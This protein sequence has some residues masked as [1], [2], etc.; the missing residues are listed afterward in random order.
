MSEYLA[1]YGRPNHLSCQSAHFKYEASRND[2]K[3]SVVS[4]YKTSGQPHAEYVAV[5]NDKISGRYLKHGVIT[6]FW[7]NGKKQF[8]EYYVDGFAVGFH[9]YFD[10]AER[11]VYVADYSASDYE[12]NKRI[13]VGKL[14]KF[15]QGSSNWAN[16]SLSDRTQ[17][18]RTVYAIENSQSVRKAFATAGLFF[19]S[20]IELDLNS[21]VAQWTSPGNQGKVT[22]DNRAY[23]VVNSELDYMPFFEVF[24]RHKLSLPGL[25][26]PK[27]FNQELLDSPWIDQA[28]RLGLEDERFKFKPVTAVSPEEIAATPQARYAKC[29]AQPS[30]ECLF[31]QITENLSFEQNHRDTYLIEFGLGALAGGYPEWTRKLTTNGLAITENPISLTTEFVKARSLKAQAEW[32]LGF[33]QDAQQSVEKAI[34]GAASAGIEYPHGQRHLKAIDAVLPLFLSDIVPSGPEKSLDLYQTAESKRILNA[35][36]VLEASAIAQARRGAIQEASRLM[37]VLAPA[38]DTTAASLSDLQTNKEKQ[39]ELFTKIMLALAEGRLER[40]DANSTRKALSELEQGEP[41]FL[42]ETTLAIRASILYAR[43]GEVGKAVNATPKINHYIPPDLEDIAVAFCKA[44]EIQAGKALANSMAKFEEHEKF[45]KKSFI[46]K[47]KLAKIEF[48]CGN[49][50]K[51]KT[52]FISALTEAKNY[53]C[54]SDFCD[55]DRLINDVKLGILATGWLEPIWQRGEREDG[56]LALKIA[57]QRAEQGEAQIALER[58]D[59][60]ATNKPSRAHIVYPLTYALAKA[61]ILVKLG[62]DNEAESEFTTARHIAVSDNHSHIRAYG[63]LELAKSLQRLKQN[64][65]AIRYAKEAFNEL[66]NDLPNG[67]VQFAQNSFV[68]EGIVKLL[69]QMGAEADALE[70]AR[71]TLAPEQFAQKSVRE[72][73]RQRVLAEIALVKFQNEAH[74]PLLDAITTVQPLNVR[75][76]NW[77]GALTIAEN[78][79]DEEEHDFVES[80][81]SNELQQLPDSLNIG[82]TPAER[83]QAIHMS[84]VLLQSDKLPFDS[85]KRLALL[86]ALAETARS[87]DNQFGTK[88]LCELAY[89]AMAIQQSAQA[90]AWFQEAKQRASKYFSSNTSISES[91][92]GACAHWAKTAG[93]SALAN[94]MLA[95]LIKQLPE[96]LDNIS[97]QIHILLNVAIAYAEYER[98]EIFWAEYGR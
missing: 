79:E 71:G 24:L 76:R 12:F 8:E 23:D 67:K 36:K 68:N 83:R 37:E 66:V 82:M 95:E 75:L 6:A 46:T 34:N 27:P 96:N 16:A 43:L 62:R 49:P 48:F 81:I 22:I 1:G 44:N 69:A 65:K 39:P 5:K 56:L 4:R 11:L 31:E 72:Q 13:G 42:Q 85:A 97:H 54:H 80:V 91:S 7:P 74:T 45:K 32:Q 77:Q 52:D 93:D 40:G 51:A 61:Q 30:T 50:Q 21:T 73:S 94:D 2:D 53:G 38:S 17:L 86:D 35:F 33:G 19:P 28:M 64:E 90:S 84:A 25:R 89:T 88:A 26:E 41:Y 57:V 60:L 10:E 70:I 9:R 63:L 78:R 87:T 29:R 47:A 59:D 55:P 58:L 14:R 3:I 98:G 20:W 92:L 18:F 15:Y